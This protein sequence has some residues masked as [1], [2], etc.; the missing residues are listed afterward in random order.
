MLMYRKSHTMF[1]I[2]CLLAIV[3]VAYSQPAYANPPLQDLPNLAAVLEVTTD[4]VEI[5]P[6]GTTQWIA[7]S[8]RSGVSAGDSIRTDNTGSA[9]LVWFED[10]TLI[11]IEPNSWLYINEFKG[12]GPSG[13]FS[14]DIT[15]VVGRI[16][17]NVS[18]LVDPN[19]RYTVKTPT[20]QTSVRGTIF[21]VDVSPRLETTLVVNDGSVAGTQGTPASVLFEINAG[22]WVRSGLQEPFGSSLT[23]A[24]A[25]ND[26]VVLALIAGGQNL[27]SGG[28]PLSTPEPADDTPRPAATAEP[29][30][31]T[32]PVATAEP[33][34]DNGN[35]DHGGD[36]DN[37][38][39]NDNTNDNG[40][41][42]DDSGDDD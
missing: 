31:G 18:T 21:G 39:S 28:T 29:V 34:N 41:D 35:D 26:P 22:F 14:I 12:T 9:F 17:N 36:D 25:G 33:S 20:M 5:L 3:V 27:Q 15:L 10:G 13:L 40:N 11:E 23:F 6:N 1:L 42:N 19:S 30:G 4:G 8:G 32:G 2:V 7:V 37:S 38:N 16:F 24:E